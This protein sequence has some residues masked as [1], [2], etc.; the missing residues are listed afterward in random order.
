MPTP[1]RQISAGLILF[2][3][4]LS[5]Q[6]KLLKKPKK[7]KEKRNCIKERKIKH[8]VKDES[9]VGE[10][11]TYTEDAILGLSQANHPLSCA[12]TF[13]LDNE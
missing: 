5:H 13:Q 1:N 8:Q 12:L 9:T 10:K 2:F 11:L 7:K 3:E 4:L 6:N